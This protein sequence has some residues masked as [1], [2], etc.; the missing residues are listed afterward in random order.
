M[1]AKIRKNHKIYLSEYFLETALN[2]TFQILS[3][4]KQMMK[5]L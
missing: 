5:F 4:D 3:L 1:K 2:L